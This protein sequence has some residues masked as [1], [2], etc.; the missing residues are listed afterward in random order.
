MSFSTPPF[1]T[2]DGDLSVHNKSGA[3]LTM[4]FT[5]DDG[6]ARDVSSDTIAF[7]TS[8]GD[9][10]VLTNGT[11]ADVKILT[12]AA[13]QL[14]ANLNK[15]VLFVIVDESSTPQEALWEGRLVIRGFA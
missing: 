13:N 4:A 14:S 3:V 7:I 2:P 9:R 8:T 6:T 12:I 15:Q 11:T 5:N 10:I 1:V